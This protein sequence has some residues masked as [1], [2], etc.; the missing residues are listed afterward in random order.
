MGNIII[1]LLKNRAWIS[2]NN[3][4]RII[5]HKG[6]FDDSSFRMLDLFLKLISKSFNKNSPHLHR[7]YFA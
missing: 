5:T 3:D 4:M 6:P 7:R 2:K 1:E